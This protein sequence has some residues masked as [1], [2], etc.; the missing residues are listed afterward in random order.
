MATI[1]DHV[2]NLKFKRIARSTSFRW[3]WIFIVGRRL[4]KKMCRKSEKKKPPRNS[5]QNRRLRC[6]LRDVKNFVR[7]RQSNYSRI[8]T[9]RRVPESWC[10]PTRRPAHG[11][12]RLKTER[13][14]KGYTNIIYVRE[15]RTRIA[16][17]F[18][19][20]SSRPETTCRRV[21]KMSV[22]SS[23]AA[24]QSEL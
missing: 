23:W 8:I 10:E 6:G 7:V 3:Q 2:F 5:T 1:S 9:R 18:F 20:S 16:R 19:F 14:P 12:R 24:R 11:P 21:D 15:N 13:N 17:Y 4:K 22:L